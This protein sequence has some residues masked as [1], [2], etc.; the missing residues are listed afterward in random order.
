MPSGKFV[1][2][3]PLFVLF[4]TPS[5]VPAYA[6]PSGA[7][8]MSC[9]TL[10]SSVATDDQVAPPSVERYMPPPDKLA[11]ARPAST[12]LE[13]MGE[14]WTSSMSPPYGPSACQFETS[15]AG[16]RV[17]ASSADPWNARTW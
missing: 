8:A 11:G 17:A 15:G 7:N 4:H 1:N 13:L 14:T 2:E 5:I 16:G 6:V 12:M 9:T 3:A 10:P